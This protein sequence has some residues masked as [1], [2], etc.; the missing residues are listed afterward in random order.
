M[1]H[2][3]C[4]SGYRGHFPNWKEHICALL[5][6]SQNRY[7]NLIFIIEQS[8]SSTVPTTIFIMVSYGKLIVGWSKCMHWAVQILFCL[9]MHHPPD[10]WCYLINIF[11]LYKNTWKQSITRIRAL[12]WHKTNNNQPDI[13]CMPQFQ[14]VTKITSYI[15]L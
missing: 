5:L 12:C 15:L 14:V 7:G 10:G 4:S 1:K 2:S 9:F 11:C 13:S 8:H 6:P 3:I